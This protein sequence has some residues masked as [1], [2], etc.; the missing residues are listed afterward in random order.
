M[1]LTLAQLRRSVGQRVGNCLVGQATANGTTT[2]FF[3]TVRLVRDNAW[4]TSASGVFAGGTPANV[5]QR[6]RVVGNAREGG[7]VTFVPAVSA[8]TQVG[9]VLELYGDLDASAG[10]DEID[11]A[12]RRAV[13]VAANVTLVPV[14]GPAFAWSAQS[15]R[16]TIP[17][18]WRGVS[19]VEV[20][21]VDGNWRPLPPADVSVSAHDRSLTLSGISSAR[22]D[23]LAVRL[24]GW[25]PPV[26]PQSDDDMVA[27]H[28]GWVEAR[29]ASELCMATA[30]RLDPTKGT[31][32][33]R[34]SATLAQEAKTLES[35][36]RFRPKGRLWVVPAS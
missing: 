14:L 16:V 12:I 36:V 6:V 5:G 13:R 27:V 1:S 35:A 23:G 33:E 30:M 28:E 4:L 2:S 11:D 8:A 29:A 21:G 15:P 26:A 17:D 10:V 31:A 20:S 25:Q 34:R 3:D 9:D 18:G 7:Q 32:M 24:L 22:A 19:G